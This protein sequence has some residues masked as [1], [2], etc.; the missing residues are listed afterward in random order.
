[1]KKENYYSFFCLMVTSCKVDRSLTD[2]FWTESK[3]NIWGS[4]VVDG[5][6]VLAGFLLGVGLAG[7]WM[8]FG[9][10]RFMV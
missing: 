6:V 9:G 10:W 8:V 4:W 7:W 5:L 3:R 1:M 2:Q